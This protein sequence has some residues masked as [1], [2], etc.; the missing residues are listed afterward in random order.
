[1]HSLT[2][3]SDR[4]KALRATA[5]RAEAERAE[6]TATIMNWRGLS[7]NWR[8]QRRG[9]MGNP[10]T[11]PTKGLDDYFKTCDK[12]GAAVPYVDVEKATKDKKGHGWTT[13]MYQDTLLTRCMVAPNEEDSMYSTVS[14]ISHRNLRLCAG[15]VRAFGRAPLVPVAFFRS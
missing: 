7:A 9:G 1:V 15:C 10:C 3:L 6:D 5:L 13:Q 11:A 8:G 14:M 2:L 12:A 4:F